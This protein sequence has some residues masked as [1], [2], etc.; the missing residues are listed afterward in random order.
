MANRQRREAISSHQRYREDRFRQAIRASKRMK[1]I[2]KSPHKVIKAIW[3][4]EISNNQIPDGSGYKTLFRLLRQG[5]VNNRLRRLQFFEEII[6]LGGGRLFTVTS[7]INILMVILEHQEYWIRPLH[8]CALVKRKDPRKVLASLLHHLFVRYEMPAFMDRVWETGNNIHISWYL[9]LGE[10]KNLRTAQLL[11]MKVSKKLAFFFLK[12]PGSYSV[13]QALR[14][15][16]VRASGGTHALAQSIANSYL[17][18]KIEGHEN[19]WQSVIDFFVRQ[20]ETLNL[21]QVGPIIDYILSR[22]YLHRRWEDQVLPPEQP[23]FS[24]KGRTLDTLMRDMD[25]WHRDMA[26]NPLNYQYIDD[27]L[28]MQRIAQEEAENADNI[29]DFWKNNKDW[30]KKFEKKWASFGV[31]IFEYREGAGKGQRV[32]TIRHLKN[33]QQLITEGSSMQHCVASYAYRCE[34]GIS[35]IFA[36]EVKAEKKSEKLATIELN[37]FKKVVQARARRNATPSDVAKRVIRLWAAH[38]GINY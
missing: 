12:A 15:S 9:H 28:D 25:R 33:A 3:D 35:A 19:F 10:G 29:Q 4:G 30:W 5:A 1:K 23:N 37:A 27:R 32:F 21:V 7:A 18:E 13:N 20:Q 24:M 17:G 11:P 26:A 22:R 8:S 6:S 34:T 16:Q 31:R 36:L 14:W 38:N 2:G